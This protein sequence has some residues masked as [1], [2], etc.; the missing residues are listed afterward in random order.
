MTTLLPMRWTHHRSS[1]FPA[2]PYDG[3]QN[4]LQR[5]FEEPIAQ[6]EAFSWT[7][8]VDVEEND[9]ELTLTAEMPGMQETDVDIEVEGNVLTL[10]GEKKEERHSEEKD[11]L[12]L[13][14]WERRYGSFTRSFTLPITV[15]EEK[16]K[17]E[18]VDGVLTVH[19]PK[20]AEAKGRRIAIKAKA[21][22]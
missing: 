22:K 21:K 13:R 9:S 5:F 8:I 7:P 18:F 16:I 14:I 20:T 11:G 15:N 1:P 2:V 17:A 12:N 19:L 10:S 6:A 4:R 3:F